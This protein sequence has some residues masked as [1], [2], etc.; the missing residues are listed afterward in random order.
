MKFPTI[1]TPIPNKKSQATSKY[2]KTHQPKIPIDRT[3]SLPDPLL[4]HILSFLPTED[5][6][7]TSF[8]SKRWQH[9]WASFPNLTFRCRRSWKEVLREFIGFVNG[10]VR[11]YGSS[12]LK[13]FSVDF[14]FLGLFADRISVW[15][16][17]ATR[18]NVE[19][20]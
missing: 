20:I 18:H 8:L 5:A 4:C 6:I 16:R 1:P 19:E 9:L 12:N 11:R 7:T 2:P 10:I 13:K 3:S 14:D 17:F 15:I